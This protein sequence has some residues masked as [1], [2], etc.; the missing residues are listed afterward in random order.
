MNPKTIAIGLVLLAFVWAYLAFQSYLRGKTGICLAQSAAGVAFAVR[1][2]I[3][4]RK[5]ST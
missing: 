1:G 3:E 2:V 5:A 4:W